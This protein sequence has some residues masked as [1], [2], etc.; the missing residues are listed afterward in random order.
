MR[1]CP[2][3]LGAARAS[4]AAFA[5]EVDGKVISHVDVLQTDW[6]LTHRQFAEAHALVD[7]VRVADAA[8]RRASD[9]HRSQR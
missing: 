3:A 8:H 2:P 7:Q 9:R 6:P 1:W 4:L 5:E